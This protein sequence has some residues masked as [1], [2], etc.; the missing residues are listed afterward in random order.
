MLDVVQSKAWPMIYVNRS[1]ENRVVLFGTIKVDPPVFY[2]HP[3]DSIILSAGAGDKR[4]SLLRKTP[5]GKSSGKVDSPLDVPALI[6]LL[7]DEPAVDEKNGKVY[8]LGLSYSHI[9]TIL[10]QLCKD[11]S[12]GAKFKIQD[13]AASTE[14]PEDMVGRPEK[15]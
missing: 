7:G 14:A 5:S 3:D 12:I 6:A 4:I 8:G 13:F 15:D 1:R 10:H 11:G 9:V 2:C